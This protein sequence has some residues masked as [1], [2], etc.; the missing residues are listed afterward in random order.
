MKYHYQSYSLFVFFAFLVSFAKLPENCTVFQH[1]HS[2]SDFEKLYK[3]C[4]LEGFITFKVFSMAM[5]GFGKMNLKNRDVITIIDLT[6]PSTEKRFFVIDLKSKKLLYDCYTAHGKNSGENYALAF[7]DKAGS[8]MSSQ[9]FFITGET[10]IGKHGYSLKL[11]GVEN[12]INSNAREREIVIHGADYVSGD[13]IKMHGRLGRSWGCPALPV[14]LAKNIID[15]IKDGT[16][17]F[18]YT[19]D[20]KYIKNSEFVNE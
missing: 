11:D 20:S 12:G 1:N 7:S 4:K 5:G 19:N 17:L 6:K 13:F 15:K 16:G 9:G 2:F 3:E 10:Y 14:E 8:L 18:I